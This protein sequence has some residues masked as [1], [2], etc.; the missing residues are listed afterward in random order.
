MNVNPSHTLT[1]E[2]PV[3]VLSDLHLG[4][5]HCRRADFLKLLDHF[6]EP[7]TMIFAGDTFDRPEETCLGKEDQAVWER[8]TTRACV[9]PVFIRGNHDENAAWFN[10][11]IFPLLPEVAIP[12]VNMIV[13]H[14]DNFQINRGHHRLFL[15]LF[16]HLH[17]LRLR[18]GAPP[19]HVAEYAKH[20]S[21]FYRVLRRIVRENAV[22]YA[23]EKGAEV[24]VC[25]HVHFAEDTWVK[26]V[27]YLNTGCWTE[28]DPRYL[29]IRDGH[30]ELK[31]LRP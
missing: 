9:T 10:P 15:F 5:P 17:R 11:D 4:S 13:C 29:M 30:V 1:V 8:L 6:Q 25:G 27:R 18:L 24:I 3:I 14:G 2:T 16:R 21:V 20:W 31:A 19:V 28:P 7:V 22:D 23:R 26:G 12:S